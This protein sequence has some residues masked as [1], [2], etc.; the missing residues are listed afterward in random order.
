MKP[1]HTSGLTLSSILSETWQLRASIP[2]SY[3]LSN[4][5]SISGQHLYNW[6]RLHMGFHGSCIKQY[7][8]WHFPRVRLWKVNTELIRNWNIIA[9][10]ISK[11]IKRWDSWEQASLLRG[12]VQPHP[13]STNPS[14]WWEVCKHHRGFLMVITLSSHY[15]TST[16]GL[17]L[18]T[19]GLT[20]LLP[21]NISVRSSSKPSE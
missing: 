15:W 16:V 20:P 14:N 11:L 8:I 6:V 9:M 4:T 21:M 7:W 1:L 19:A 2:V 18:L 5:H 12:E 3:T 17:T 10:K 13:I